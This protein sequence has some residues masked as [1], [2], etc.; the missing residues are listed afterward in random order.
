VTARALWFGPG[1]RPLFGWVHAPDDGRV[2]GA[3]VLCPPLG[4]EG[5]CSYRA[6]RR[7]AEEMAA[8]GIAVVRFDYDG[9]GDSAGSQD[10][11]GRIEAWSASVR[12]AIDLIR[13]A[14]AAKVV[15]VGMR[16]G[17]TIAACEL[18]AGG[19]VDGVVLWDP[20]ASGRSY[21]REQQA[22]GLFSIGAAA[23]DDG[24]VEVPGIVYE[25][26]TVK[27][28]SS[29][30]IAD[31]EGPLAERVLVLIRP[32]RTANKA[33]RGRLEMDHVEWADAVGQ[34]EF[35]D[36][37]PW[38]VVDPVATIDTVTSWV[39]EVIGT[40][41]SQVSVPT[42][43][44]A[45][46]DRLG[47]GRGI[48]ER[49]VTLGEVGLFG[50]VTEA[51][52]PSGGSHSTTGPT[53][54]LL[55]AGVI[56]HV[57]PSRLWVEFARRWAAGGVRV[58][59]F[60]QSGLGDS[61]VRPGQREDQVYAPEAFD[62]LGEVV[63][64]MA[65]GDPRTVILS[66]LCSGGYHSIEGGISLGVGSVCLINPVL[67]AAPA[68][69][70]AADNPGTTDIDPRRQATT[71]RKKWVRAL[72]AHDFLGSIVDR[73]PDGAWWI[74]NRVAVGTPPARIIEKL[75][76][77]GVDTFI[78]CGEKEASAMRRGQAAAF[79]RLA[80]TGRFHLEVMPG[81]DH[82]LFARASRDRVGPVITERILRSVTTADPA[83]RV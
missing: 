4:L 26:D 14:G 32:D 20:C 37:E 47:E 55:N 46:L 82:E 75:V 18:A 34:S 43:T 48:V 40:D 59:R 12:S 66:G 22:L 58:L 8:A 5:V 30:S 27:E 23:R 45:V 76:E 63:A 6:F 39:S 17:A 68:E 33:M 78:V 25:A 7:M 62:D 79:R 31:T 65:A 57:G 35:V 51:A 53:A 54:I 64:A 44:E 2:R 28:L 73:L 15:V 21:L 3:V 36:V 9:T 61:P 72:P 49:I 41:L 24:S 83:R 1:E 74:I 60:D 77:S 38:Q 56:S 50:I 13:N 42:S 71:V 10:E 67:T 19:G 52:G 11:P 29:L 70:H 69:T 80:R 81:I 16:V